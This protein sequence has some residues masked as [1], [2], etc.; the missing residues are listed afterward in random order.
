MPHA[1]AQRREGMMHEK[2]YRPYL[3]LVAPARTIERS[4]ETD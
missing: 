2:L 3:R 4:A 1:K